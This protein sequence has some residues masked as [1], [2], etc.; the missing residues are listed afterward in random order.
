MAVK[1]KET[2]FKSKYEMLCK[3]VA[4]HGVLKNDAMLHQ[5]LIEYGKLVD[6]NEKLWKD[7][8]EKGTTFID[9]RSGKVMQNPAIAAIN[10][11]HGQMLKMSQYLDEKTKAIVI[12]D[13]KK[14]W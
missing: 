1:K 14:S 8:E 12:S 13:G 3:K 11:N 6:L 4:E 7:V 2:D 5:T 10:K 9:E